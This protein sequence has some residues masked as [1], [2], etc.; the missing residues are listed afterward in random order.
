MECFGVSSIKSLSSGATSVTWKRVPGWPGAV[1]S[2]PRLPSSQQRDIRVDCGCWGCAHHQ[3]RGASNLPLQ[4]R[5]VIASWFILL[6]QC[7]V[8]AVVCGQETKEK[9][10]DDAAREISKQDGAEAGEPT[11]KYTS[12]GKSA[13]R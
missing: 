11:S 9:Q 4:V 13:S 6:G 5:H 2:S 12:F 10:Q 8:A 1:P 3:V 7:V